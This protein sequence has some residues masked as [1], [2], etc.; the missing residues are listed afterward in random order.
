M[1]A[2][3]LEQLHQPRSL[4]FTRTDIEPRISRAD[5]DA[6]ADAARTAADSAK[7]IARTRCAARV[8]EIAAELEALHRD[9]LRDRVSTPAS[10]RQYDYARRALRNLGEILTESK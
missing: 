5:E 1:T 6:I 10:Y 7:A 4:H 8:A 3:Q 9:T 2:R